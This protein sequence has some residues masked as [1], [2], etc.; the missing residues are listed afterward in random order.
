MV[1]NRKTIN[2][3]AVVSKINYPAQAGGL[4]IKGGA[5]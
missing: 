1:K 2:K 5:E 4:E 3:T